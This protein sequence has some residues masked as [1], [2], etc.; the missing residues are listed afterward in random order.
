MS[1]FVVGLTGGIGSGKTTIANLFAQYGI[2]IIDADVIAR[3]VVEPPSDA[4]KQISHYFGDNILDN[5]GALNRTKLREF[6]FQNTAAKTWLNNLLHPIIRS[7]MINAIK[8]AQSDYCL[9][10]VPLLVENELTYLVNRVLVVDVPTEVQISR[11]CARD[12][13]SKEIVQGIITSQATREQRISVA[14]DIIDNN[15][16]NNDTI[17]NEVAKLHQLYIRLANQ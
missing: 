11:T 3:K 9:L 15:V 17:K 1:K 5:N 13:S 6:V 14:D 2:D 8:Q 7:E 10:V 16:T 12:E 4:L